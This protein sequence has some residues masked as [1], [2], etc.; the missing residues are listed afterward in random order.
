MNEK[1]NKEALGN[2]LNKNKEKKLNQSTTVQQNIHK[3]S[4][5]SSTKQSNSTIC[6]Q[7]SESISPSLLERNY[8]GLSTSESSSNDNLSYKDVEKKKSIFGKRD[9]SRFTFVSEPQESPS[10]SVMIPEYISEIISFNTSTY[11]LLRNV[12]M[13]EEKNKNKIQVE[14]EWKNIPILNQ[15]E[16]LAD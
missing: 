15:T 7:T 6:A 4:N 16:V 8:S 3:S 14:G 9:K 11:F 13:K 12:A 10:E 1:N 5:A 2:I